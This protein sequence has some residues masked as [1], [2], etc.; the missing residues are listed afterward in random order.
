MA[1]LVT[2]AHHDPG[3][4]LTV[5][6]RPVVPSYTAPCTASS[7]SMGLHDAVTFTGALSDADLADRHGPIRRARDHLAAR[8]LRRARARGHDDR[9]A[10]RGQP[11]RRAAR[12]GGRRR[13]AG[14]RHA[15]PR[16]SPAP[17]PACWAEPGLRERWPAPAARRIADLDLASAGER[18]VDLV[19]ALAP[20]RTAA[21]PGGRAA[22]EAPTAACTRDT[23]RRVEAARSKL[24]ARSRPAA[25]SSRAQRRVVEHPADGRRERH[26]GLVRQHQPGAAHRLGHRGDAV[27][28]DRDAVA[29]R[30]GQG[31]AEALVVRGA[32]EDVGRPVVGLELGA[33]DRAGAGSTASVRPSSAMKARSAGS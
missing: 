23:K 5:V 12:G 11:G 2:R 26:G 4:T 32:D 1:L 33:A 18:A 19:A 6:G 3:A 14:R 21:A 17:S 25:V 13:P 20:D 22:Q 16:R 28:D 29:H 27:G 10:G 30:L 15:T 24:A 31:D 9:A 7:T 8:G